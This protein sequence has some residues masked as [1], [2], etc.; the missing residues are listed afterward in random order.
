MAALLILSI[1]VATYLIAITVVVVAQ[2]VHLLAG[3]ALFALI[4]FGAVKLF[5]S[6]L[7]RL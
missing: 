2:E 6:R 3:I 5:Q 7:T 4:G 1:A